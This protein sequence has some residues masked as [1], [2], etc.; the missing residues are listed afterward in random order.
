MF[1]RLFREKIRDWVI[2][3]ETPVLAGKAGEVFFP[4]L[5]FC[6]AETG[7]TVHLE[8]F[9]RWHKHTFP[10]RLAFL[11]EH[12][13]TPLILGA[14][15]GAVSEEKWNELVRTFPGA[16]ERCFRFRDFPGI[17]N[18]VKTLNRYTENQK[19]NKKT[20]SIL[21]SNNIISDIII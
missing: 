9:H 18:V 12:P 21:V 5:S 8:L 19:E 4:D 13:E 2:V 1:H 14:D 10:R 6:H 20:Y 15:R 7:K 17:E 3:G 16:A 11:E